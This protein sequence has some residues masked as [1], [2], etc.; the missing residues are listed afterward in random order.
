MAFSFFGLFGC[1]QS[2]A[3]FKTL[4]VKAFSAFPEENDVVL[5]C[6]LS[7]THLIETF[8]SL[9]SPLIQGDGIYERTSVRAMTEQVFKII[10]ERLYPKVYSFAFRSCGQQWLAEEISHNVFCKLWMHR[11]GLHCDDGC[12][13]DKA[14]PSISGYV[15]M[16]ARN[17][18]ID[19]YRMASKIEEYRDNFA[20][21]L[22]LETNM[23]DRIDARTCI[24]IVDRVVGAMPPVRKQ[25]FTMS[26]FYH[27]TSKEIAD[28]MALSRRTVERHIY[29]ALQQL[30]NELA[31]YRY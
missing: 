25:V 7:Y 1:G 12:S 20:A 13:V 23:E 19:Y 11:Q 14:L 18:V 31:T 24:G 5:L 27:M 16:M 21:E 28:R 26:R 17:E 22:C 29:L 8:L 30:R 2:R 4:D 3:P 6:I 15:F 9:P 10:F